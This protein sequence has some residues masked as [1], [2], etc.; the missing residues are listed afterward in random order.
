[1]SGFPCS[2]CGQYG[3]F[4]NNQKSKGALRRCVDCVNGIVRCAECDKVFC[5]E[6]ALRQH[7]NSG[8]HRQ[9]DFPCPGCSRKFRGMTDT[10]L[11]F[12]SGSCPSCRGEANAKRA[13]YEL[14]ANQR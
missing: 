6:R 11:H 9:R 7:L 12:E 5:D 8:T 4:S 13:A 3:Q 10:A 1:M 14:I 2:A